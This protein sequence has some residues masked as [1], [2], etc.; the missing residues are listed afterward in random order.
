M[1]EREM[2]KAYGPSGYVEN[3]NTVVDDLA[4]AAFWEFDARRNGDGKWKEAPQS[5]RDAFKAVARGLI[6]RT[7]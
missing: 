5:E 1:S 2:R 6:R 4:E 3:P 7:T